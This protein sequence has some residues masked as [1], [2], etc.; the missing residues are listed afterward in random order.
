MRI[1]V[2][3]LF[4]TKKTTISSVLIDGKL[5]CFGLENTFNQP[6]ILG[7]TRIPCGTYRVGLRTVGGKHRKYLKR[8]PTL[9]KGMLHIKDV[10]GFEH[11]LIH[12][13]NFHQDT[14]GCLLLGRSVAH[15][16]ETGYMVSDSKAA[17]KEFYAKVIAAARNG[18]LEIDVRDDGFYC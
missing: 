5:Q 4:R 8:F 17:Y 10:P 6:K 18:D 13:G 3:R 16:S 7:K 15:R 1:L 11:I 9:H 12:I 2:K 14:D